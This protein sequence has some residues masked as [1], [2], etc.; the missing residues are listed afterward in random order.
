M[1]VLLIEKNYYNSVFIE[2]IDFMQKQ[3]EKKTMKA[4]DNDEE[5]VVIIP[6]LVSISFSSYCCK[7]HCCIFNQ[8]MLHIVV[9]ILITKYILDVKLHTYQ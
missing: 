9:H 7:I 1:G 4:T 8:L 5:T 2:R 3:K 6:T